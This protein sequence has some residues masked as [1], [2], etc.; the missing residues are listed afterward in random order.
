MI[1]I[2]IFLSLL[3]QCVWLYALMASLD[4]LID[5]DTTADLRRLLRGCASLRHQMVKKIEL[6]KNEYD[7]MAELFPVA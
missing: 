1:C 5:D 7:R 6:W 3:P 4:R 2:Y